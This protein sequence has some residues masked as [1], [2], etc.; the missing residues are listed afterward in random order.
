[1]R[2]IG[3]GPWGAGVWFGDSQQ[4]FLTVWLATTLLQRPVLDYYVYDHFCEN[5]GNQCFVLGSKGCQMC[6]AQ[7]RVTNVQ[8]SRCGMADYDAMIL[9]FSGKQ[10][11]ELYLALQNVGQP[12]TQVFDS[13]T[14]WE[15]TPYQLATPV[16]PSSGNPYGA[17]GWQQPTFPS[18][19]TTWQVNQGDQSTTCIHLLFNKQLCWHNLFAGWR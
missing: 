15:A 16:V 11:K 5:P 2:R 3:T 19:S 6:I 7:S 13:L 17:S 18:Y 8:G 9:R 1:V 4:Y 12:P 10:S 14:G